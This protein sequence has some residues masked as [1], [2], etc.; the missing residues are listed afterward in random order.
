VQREARPTS[1]VRDIMVR[2]YDIC[3]DPDT[4]LTE[5]LPRLATSKLRRL[6]VCRDGRLYGLLLVTD[7]MRVLEARPVPEE[8]A[9]PTAVARSSSSA[10]RVRTSAT[11]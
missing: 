6:L 1:R 5:A 11:A 9:Q 10:S 2:A 4:P 3:V 7:A 8:P